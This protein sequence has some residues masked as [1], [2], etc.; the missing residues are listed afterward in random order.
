MLWVLGWLDDKGLPIPKVTNASSRGYNYACCYID[1][2][3]G[4]F[5]RLSDTISES[6]YGIF[7]DLPQ[8]VL[9]VLK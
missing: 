8:I 9:S 5:F 3:R 7:T 1:I 6:Y 4:F 2:A